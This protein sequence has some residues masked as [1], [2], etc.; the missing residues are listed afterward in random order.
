MFRKLSPYHALC[1]GVKTRSLLAVG[2]PTKQKHDR[3]PAAGAKCFFNQHCPFIFPL[4]LRYKWHIALC[5][6]ALLFYTINT[7]SLGEKITAQEISSSLQ[8]V[9]NGN[10]NIPFL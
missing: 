7:E 6:G 3:G 5:N 10:Q 1:L 9:V 8:E 2:V 4:L